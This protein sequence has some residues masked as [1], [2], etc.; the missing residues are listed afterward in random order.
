MRPILK[1]GVA[2]QRKTDVSAITASTH[3]S[4]QSSSLSGVHICAF[5][6]RSKLLVMSAERLKDNQVYASPCLL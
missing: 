2:L 3:T 1:G 5:Y 4:I 6:S